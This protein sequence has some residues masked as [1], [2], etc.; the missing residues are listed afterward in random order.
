[1][2]KDR[3]KTLNL[4]LAS[5]LLFLL[6][7]IFARI[8]EWTFGFEIKLISFLLVGFIYGTRYSLK[9]DKTIK[10]RAKALM[11]FSFVIVEVLVMLN[12]RPVPYFAYFALAFGIFWIILEL[13]DKLKSD[14][15]NQKTNVFLMIGLSLLIYYVL[16][17]FLQWPFLGVAFLGGVF[18]TS[19]GFFIE[20]LRFKKVQNI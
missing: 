6:F 14:K 13:I 11:V 4:P 7:A 1:M 18:L 9:I 15:S 5:A 17:R 10:D 8:N 12:V 2:N 20:H 19:I 3:Y 16:A